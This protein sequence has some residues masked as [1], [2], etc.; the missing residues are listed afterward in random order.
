SKA[1]MRT[2]GDSF[3]HP[4]LAMIKIRLGSISSAKFSECFLQVSR[5]SRFQPLRQNAIFPPFATPRTPQV[6]CAAVTAYS[7]EGVRSGLLGFRFLPG[8]ARCLAAFWNV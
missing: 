4:G 8:S 2:T 6:G 7:M 1:F 3:F 5:I